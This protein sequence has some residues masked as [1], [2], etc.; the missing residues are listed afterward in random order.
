MKQMSELLP[1]K[2]TDISVYPYGSDLWSMNPSIMRDNTDG[3]WR[4]VVRIVDYCMPNGVTIRSK[5]AG[6]GHQTRNAMLILDPKTWKPIQIFKM[7]ERDDHPRVTCPNIGYE[8]MRVFRTDRG[9]LQGIAASLHLKRDSRSAAGGS[10]HQP[11]EQVLLSFDAEYNIVTARPIRGDGFSGAPQKNWVPF[12]HCLEPR[13]LYSIDKGT[14]F[15]DR[16]PVHSDAA[17]ARA[18]TNAPPVLAILPFQQAPPPTKPPDSSPVPAAPSAKP[19][20]TLIRSSTEAQLVRGRRVMVDAAATRPTGTTRYRGARSGGD[21]SRSLG[22]GRVLLPKYEGLR[23]GTQLVRVGEDAWLG[24]GHEMKFVDAR[25]FYWHVWYLVDSKGKMVAASEPCKLAPEGI[26]FAAGMAIEGDRV[27]V[28]FGVDDMYARLGE[29][30][31]S[32]VM[33]ILRPVER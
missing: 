10:S 23:G 21:A 26:E 13:F 1:W 25:K 5:K 6:P 31:L 17:V 12:D 19:P 8:D 3:T 2:M 15:D 11:P 4:C 30:Q 16:G 20:R 28:S 7:E 29:T 27:V 24:I 32:A 33:G 18:S 9:G 22:T 14:M